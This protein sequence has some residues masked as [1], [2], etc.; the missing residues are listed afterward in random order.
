MREKRGKGENARAKEGSV[1]ASLLRQG[2]RK[3]VCRRGAS[4]EEEKQVRHMPERDSKSKQPRRF[5]GLTPTEDGKKSV[6]ASYI[7]IWQSCHKGAREKKKMFYRLNL[8]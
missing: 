7:E 2:N 1:R 3:I 8:H 5:L 6:V 4:Q